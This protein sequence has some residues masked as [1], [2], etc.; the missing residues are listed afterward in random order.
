[1]K[2]ERIF[3]QRGQSLIEALGAL[4]VLALVIST[5]SSLVV[6]SLSNAQFEKNKT[7]A[8]KYAQQGI[9]TAMAIRN[10]NYHA[11]TNYNGIYCLGQDQMNLGTSQGSCTTANIGNFIRSVQIEQTPGCSP[12]VARVV[13]YVSFTDG[14]CANGVYC[15]MKTQTVCLST[16]N[17][18]QSL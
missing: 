8:A 9:E 12:S 13:V 7:F 14:K 2:Q 10:S 15:H 5:V 18:I 16:V 1:M 17:T 4:A 6:T 11:F 3:D